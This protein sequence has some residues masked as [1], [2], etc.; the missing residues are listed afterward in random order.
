MRYPLRIICTTVA[1][2][3]LSNAVLA[4]RS[5]AAL[6]GPT[7]VAETAEVR[8]LREIHRLRQRLADLQSERHRLTAR[9]ERVAK[10]Q[11]EQINHNEP[12]DRLELADVKW[13]LEQCEQ[14]E[15]EQASDGKES[16]FPGS[17]ETRLPEYH[18]WDSAPRL[19]VQD[20]VTDESDPA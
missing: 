2:S 19:N 11:A 9:S 16:D 20:Q 17:S 13:L 5:P 8:E 7:L 18:S 12:S 6:T 4:E 1:F 14:L 3:F 10:V 15:S